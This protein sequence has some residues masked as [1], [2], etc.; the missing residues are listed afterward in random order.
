MLM[1]GLRG[2]FDIPRD[3]DREFILLS[4]KTRIEVKVEMNIS[5]AAW[6][7]DFRLLFTG[8]G[9]YEFKGDLLCF[10]I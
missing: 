4:N 10:F 6:A 3:K 5:R 2:R 1:S 9:E 7:Q 8:A